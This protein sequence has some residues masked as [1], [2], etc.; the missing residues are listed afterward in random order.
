MANSVDLDET[1]HMSSL[2]WLYTVCISIYFIPES[3]QWILPCLDLDM[4]ITA[5]RV[6]SK[7]KK[8]GTK[9]ETD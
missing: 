1:V 5:N 9:W 2:V 8:S 7:K 4:P 3:L 6:I